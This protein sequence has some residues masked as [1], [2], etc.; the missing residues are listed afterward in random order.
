MLQEKKTKLSPW[1]FYRKYYKMI[2]A[3]H[4]VQLSPRR[5]LAMCKPRLLCY[6]KW[7]EKL[8]KVGSAFL[9]SSLS[10]VPPEKNESDCDETVCK[11]RWINKVTGLRDTLPAGDLEAKLSETLMV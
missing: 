3:K 10:Q 11:Q 4:F 1:C 2:T 5:V 7:C 9:F 6:R 8:R